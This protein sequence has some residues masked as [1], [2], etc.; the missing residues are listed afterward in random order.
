MNV[1]RRES[2]ADRHVKRYPASYHLMN[3][4]SAETVPV[5]RELPGGDGCR[6]SLNIPASVEAGSRRWSD[7][8]G[9]TAEKPCGRDGLHPDAAEKT[10]AYLRHADAG[11]LLVRVTRRQQW[12]WADAGYAAWHSELPFSVYSAY[13]WVCASYYGKMELFPA[14]DRA[15]LQSGSFRSHERLRLG[16]VITEATDL[17]KARS[18]I[19]ESHTELTVALAVSLL[20]RCRM[21]NVSEY[22]S[23]RYQGPA[24]FSHRRLSA[25]MSGN[26]DRHR[27]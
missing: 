14:D 13:R 7:D 1:I 20:H 15:D 17:W 4:Q 6:D 8:A 9:T 25:S 10:P 21:Q 23:L 24:A 2:L 26:R 19:T 3:T 16:R 11:R 5:T 18:P 27:R 22:P 12:R